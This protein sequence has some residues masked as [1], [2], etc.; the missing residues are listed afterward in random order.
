MTILNADFSLFAR[1]QRSEAGRK[2]KNLIIFF[3]FIL[4]NS[5]SFAVSCGVNTTL[6]NQLFAIEKARYECNPVGSNICF[7]APW[8]FTVMPPVCN[9]PDDHQP[10]DYDD[11]GYPK[12]PNGGHPTPFNTSPLISAAAAVALG[13]LAGIAA[14]VGSPVLVTSALA[15]A[16]IGALIASSPLSNSSDS[17]LAQVPPPLQVNLTPST[18]PVPSPV[19]NDSRPPGVQ[20]SP[21]QQFAPTGPKYQDAESG[22]WE[23]ANTQTGTEYT[24]KPPATP[25]NPQ[26]S[27]TVE[28]TNNG[29]SISY[30]G[31]NP[32]NLKS[33]V[34]IDKYTD[35]SYSVTE[36]RTLSVTTLSGEQTTADASKTVL[37]SPSGSVLSTA[38]HISSSLGNGQ[39][40]DPN[41]LTFVGSGSGS[42]SGG[43][44]GGGTGGTSGGGTGGANGTGT[45]A[46]GDC[47]TETTQIANKSL[48]TD[49][50]DFF[51]Q[52]SEQSAVP[53]A[54]STADFRGAV[55]SKDTP[56]FSSL[57]GF[58]LPTHNSTCPQPSF[59]YNGQTYAF[60][61]HCDLVTDHFAAF[62]AVFTVI[63][64]LSALF[65][66]L[67][68]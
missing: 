19:L 16:A 41:T 2:A 8:T 26:P 52:P 25:S 3:G 29:Y 11:N 10:S 27:P 22:G 37:Y 46:G 24:Y 6:D 65:I 30:T 15:S 45:C 51:T 43:G 17:Q 13:L 36:S 32:N 21:E 40:A 5:A 68:A 50:K 7:I 20:V 64:T 4:F 67:R 33:G 18:D 47:A 59:D 48:L 28:I 57:L 63:F 1:L 35:G 42:G 23:S 58:Q 14:V 9:M 62:R 38:T 60:T 31:T 49:I 66:V 53:N 44:T 61:A 56:L 12:N 54:K 55:I 39:V 34:L